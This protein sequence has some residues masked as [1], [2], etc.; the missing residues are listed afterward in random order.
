M[1]GKEYGGGS[2]T[3]AMMNGQEIWMEEN[4]GLCK[5]NK[6]QPRCGLGSEASDG[7]RTVLRYSLPTL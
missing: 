2:V 7:V 1:R 5:D 4:A 3:P 6:G